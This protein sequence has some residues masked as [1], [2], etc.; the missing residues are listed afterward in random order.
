MQFNYTA[1]DAEGNEKKG[2]IDSLNVDVAISSLQRQ[3]LIVSSINPA[4]G[5]G[6]L[7]SVRLG[8]L[9]RVT[10]KEIVILSRQIATLFKADVPALRVFRMLGDATE[11]PMLKQVLVEVANDIQ[12]GSSIAAAMSK[13]PKVFSDFYVSMVRAGEETGKLHDVF[14]H[15]ADYLDR[16]YELISRARSALVYPVFVVITFVGVMLLLLWKVIPSLSEI[17]I[18][19]G[20]ELPLYTRIVLGVSDF[21]ANYTLFLFGGL[22]IGAVLFARSIRTEAGR[23][24]F[25]H[26]K[27]SVPYVGR[28]YKM[29]YLARLSDN[30]NTM[31]LSGITMIRSLES[32]AGVV[33]NRVYQQALI[34]IAESVRGGTS[35]SDAFS[36]YPEEMP[37]ILVQMIRIGEETGELGNILKTLAD[38][39]RREVNN[40]VDA[41]V[42]LIE[43]ALIILLGGG[44]GIVVASVLI[45]I[46]DIATSVA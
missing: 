11:N 6:S 35:V 17:L 29:L 33:S 31:L 21:F 10:G 22:A 19:S 41:L 39:Y 25:D 18:S 5:Q 36:R 44:V 38:F 8:F 13:H 20:Q 32:T 34:E 24:A 40:A 30:M 7:L 4:D 12:G 43:P 45:P 9:E 3:G 26:F 15:L 42:S 14:M 1:L 28:L 27:L 16:T 23:M 37:G 2:A 46:Y